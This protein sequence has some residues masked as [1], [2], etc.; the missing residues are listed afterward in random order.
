MDME[1]IPDSYLDEFLETELETQKPFTALLNYFSLK[2]ASAAL[3]NP[4]ET[5]KT[6]MQVQN[7]CV[8]VMDEVDNSQEELEAKRMKKIREAENYLMSTSLTPSFERR[9]ADSLGYVKE[10]PVGRLLL[11]NLKAGTVYNCAR[12]V[13]H[14]QGLFS[15][16]QGQLTSWTCSLCQD[17][18]ET[19]GDEIM[20]AVIE[21]DDRFASLID[22]WKYEIGS[23]VGIQLISGILL[24][25]LDLVKTRLMVQSSMAHE[26][27]YTGPYNAL[28]TIAREE[29]FLSL[30]RNI[31]LT[32]AYHFIIPVTRYVPNF[33]LSRYIE[34]TDANLVGTCFYVALRFVC[35]S[36]QLLFSM[37]I[38]TVRKRL[39]VQHN[40]I[41][42]RPFYK[43]IA[44]SHI[45]YNGAFDCF[46]RIIREEGFSSLYQGFKMQLLSNTASNIVL[47]FNIWMDSEE[48]ESYGKAI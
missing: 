20:D 12:I 21:K 14:R 31:F 18:I 44:I 6:L 2:F 41:T 30:Y 45:R 1:K 17:V 43:R 34:R 46:I 35:S 42:S 27:K 15:L 19:V 24:S 10:E 9:E 23:N 13:A 36:L 25:P 4:L 28:K 8:V 47:L 33:L 11:P 26:R 38:E 39:Q 29:G 32:A 5:C 3:L 48:E 7:S 22:N 37:P 16:W 40:A